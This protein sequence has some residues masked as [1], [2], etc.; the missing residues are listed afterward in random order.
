M[1]N[2]WQMPARDH[3]DTTCADCDY[4]GEA[5]IPGL[6]CEGCYEEHTGFKLDEVDHAS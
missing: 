4:L 2:Y 6:F 5:A 3:V 1:M